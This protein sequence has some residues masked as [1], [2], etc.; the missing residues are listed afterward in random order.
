M[1][2]A[3][4]DQLLAAVNGAL[5]VWQQ[6]WFE[7]PDDLKV[8]SCP[9]PMLACVPLEDSVQRWAI[10]RDLHFVTHRGD[11]NRYAEKALDYPIDAEG[12][13]V[14][15]LQ[16]QLRDSLRDEMLNELIHAIGA[17]I[18]PSSLEQ[19]IQAP[20]AETIRLDHGG[21][22]ITIGCLDHRPL[23]ELYC[24][25]PLLWRRTQFEQPAIPT[26]PSP[27]PRSSA[28]A[29]TELLVL[30]TL[31]ECRLTAME[32]SSLALGDVL[33]TSQVVGQSVP[34]R[35]T[36]SSHAAASILAHGQPVR[37]GD[38]VAIALTSINRQ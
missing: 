2:Q 23:L 22:R 15:A 25:T 24:S 35:L 6:Q 21:L 27:E 9:M 4:T 16:L 7:H 12:M 14:H 33:T 3:D 18:A 34:L 19:T 32:F 31:G 26:L 29:P 36:S 37:N 28:L 10:D 30:V 17:A 8:T 20:P 38:R 11:W 1:V 13:P 5:F